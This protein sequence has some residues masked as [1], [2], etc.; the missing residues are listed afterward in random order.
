MKL[1]WQQLVFLA[2]GLLC[3]PAGASATLLF[4]GGEDVDFICVGSGVCSVDTNTSSFRTAWARESIVIGG[5]NADPPPSRFTTPLFSPSSSLWIHAQFCID[6]C[7]NLGT[8]SSAQVLRLMDNLGNAALTIRGTG[9]AAQLKISSRT[10]AG[11]F[12]DLVTCSSAANQSLTQLDLFVNYGTSG[13]VALYN[14]SVKVCGY[15]G[16]VT[17]G[18]GATTLNQVEFSSA[19]YT[20]KWSEIIIA[21]TDT[22]AMARFTANTVANG[23]TTGFSGSNICSSIW[24]AVAFSDANFGYSS[25]ANVLHECTIKNTIP[26]GAYNVL[27]FVMSARALV[28]G[29]GPQHFD[30]VTRVNGTDYF[31]PD[32]TPTTTFSNFT[33]YLQTTNPATGNPW[34]IS[35][36][37]AAGFNVGE[38][39]KP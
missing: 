35:D 28:G 9:T 3:F 34:S 36:F 4:A 23:N 39:T 14:N 11:V 29:S 7:G 8:V 13:E 1:R 16:N 37:Q 12:T 10:A 19:G 17:N 33:N 32:F 21:T 31:S 15:T 5:S 24:S 38:Q 30:F 27:G 25:A 6:N 20:S 22:R 2:L 18:D 26:P